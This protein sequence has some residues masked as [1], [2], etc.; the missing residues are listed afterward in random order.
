[1]RFFYS[2]LFIG[3][4]PFIVGRL[5]WRSR[6][7]PAYRER[8][9]ERLGVYTDGEGDQGNFP[10]WFHCVSVGESEAAFPVIRG[11][12]QR[13][14]ELP[15]LVT[16]T[17]PTGSAR[18]RA[19]LGDT[20]QHVYLPYDVPFAVKRF[21]K[22][23][24]PRLGVILETE[25][26]PNLFVSCRKQGI[27]IA[28]INGRLSS[29]S[30]RGYLRLGSL[31]RESLSAVTLVAAQTW[32]DAEHYVLIGAE[33]ARVIMPGNIKFDVSQDEAMQASARQL[34]VTLFGSRPVWIAGSTHPGEDEQ[35]LAAQAVLRQQSPHALLVLAP[36]HPE[37]ADSIQRLCV[38]QGHRVV[39]RTGQRACQ[40]DEDVFILDTIGELRF[41]YAMAD[42]AYVGGSLV[43]H[44]GQNVLEPAVAGVPVLI[45]PHTYNFADIV[46]RLLAAGGAFRIRDAV[47]LGERV[48]ALLEDP[49]A[50]HTMGSQ[51]M[52]FVSSNRG[53]V[54]R[55]LDAL[56][57]L[58][59]KSA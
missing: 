37:R 29:R 49:A 14:P 17:T 46:T 28:I 25:I 56:S 50:S 8:I 10:V 31:V 3:L 45:G 33:N 48:T 24:R 58:L 40:P 35:V 11:L 26:W 4:L 55:V 34:R 1:M 18:I 13:H 38:A 20:V 52:A 27:P 57:D 32:E 43:P 53:A 44:G 9:T 22:R 39:R 47:E 54:N 21:L 23:F 36:R 59:A 41:F 30:V 6:R 7:L 19:V 42:V 51:G 2:A 15:I 16:C 5:L 12:R